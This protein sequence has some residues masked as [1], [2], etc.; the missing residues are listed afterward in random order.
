MG[1]GNRTND[2]LNSQPT[3][4]AGQVEPEVSTEDLLEEVTRG[5]GPDR[6]ELEEDADQFTV[7]EMEYD[8][9]EDIDLDDLRGSMI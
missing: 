4:F 2:K 7:F 9:E 1:R 8:D 6:E 3:R 5:I